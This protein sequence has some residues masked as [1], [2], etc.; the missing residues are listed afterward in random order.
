MIVDTHYTCIIVMV[1]SKRV[2][3]LV[4]SMY[5]TGCSGHWDNSQ[6]HLIYH[7]LSNETSSD[8]FFVF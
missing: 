8:C 6:M 5:N 7:A 3:L 1:L 2:T 4:L